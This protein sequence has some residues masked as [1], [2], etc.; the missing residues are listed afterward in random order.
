MGRV[1]LISHPG[2]AGT[3]AAGGLRRGHR[4][5]R[6]HRRQHYGDGY[7][8]RCGSCGVTVTLS[9]GATAIT[10]ATG[11][12]TFSNVPAG[13][14]TITISGHSPAAAFLSLGETT[15]ITTA[16]QV[17]TVNFAGSLI[18]T[19]AIIGSVTSAAGG[20][21]GVTVTMGSPDTR[22]L[23][24]DADGQFSAVG[25]LS[26]TY[27]I[28]ITGVPDGMTCG[29]TTQN[30][31]VAPGESKVAAFACA[32]DATA[33]I[34]GVLYIDENNKND[35]YDGSNLKDLVMAPNVAITLE[36]PSIGVKVTT[37]TD[38]TGAFSFTELVEGSYNVTIDDTDTDL[39]TDV[40]FG[41]ASP[42]ILMTLTSGG[43]GTANFAFD[44]TTQEVKVFA[45]LGRDAN[46]APAGIST[47]IGTGVAP[48]AGVIIS[49]H[50]TE[51]D[52]VGLDNALGTDTTDANGE[53]TFSFLRSA[54]TSPAG[55][56]QD[57]IV[58]AVRRGV[59]T[60]DHVANGESV[61]EI[62]YATRTKS[63]MATDTFDVLNTR[64]V[65][66]ARAVGVGTST[67]LVGW[68]S[69]LWLNDSLNVA[70]QTGVTDADGAKLYNDAVAATSLPDTFFTRLSA[71][72][73]AA[74]GTAF[75]ST[76][77]A[78][79]GTAVGSQLRFIH[80]GTVARTDT[81]YV[82]DHEV[83]FS[84]ADMQIRVYHEADDST[85]GGPP[86][87]TGGDNIE[88]TD[89]IDVDMSWGD[90]TRTLT[91]QAVDG[92]AVFL[93]VPTDMGPYTFNA[94]STVATQVVLN[95]TML[96]QT[97][98]RSPCKGRRE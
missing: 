96:T 7:G 65:M 40:A 21:E 77:V 82:G 74:G 56:T 6:S 13:S 33:S 75:T 10:T 91:A 24:T 4:Y 12:F 41:L 52:A 49:L 16:G 78:M 19:S 46:P 84:E 93:G 9:S 63:D 20:L 57:Q 72:Q 68:N 69:A 58:F 88:N 36:G 80:D 45:Y 23:I 5:G 67:G 17:A 50:P 1:V 29:T 47:T 86:M 73:A 54:D 66:K 60:V 2:G 22:V 92:V 98:A 55:S 8:R 27:T 3:S 44:I 39:P 94:R 53:A 11:Q 90:S 89:N 81:V 71:T 51:A 30:L 70:V 25:L 28:T 61:I 32:E 48:V 35:L 43:S 26:G 38:S 18:R 83:A 97:A 42:T 79:R 62:S 64:V 31:T 37:Q 34:S 15:T 59:P 14:Y 76:P 95:D 87:W 85:A